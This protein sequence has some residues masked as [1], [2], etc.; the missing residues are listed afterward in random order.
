VHIKHTL[1]IFFFFF[2]QNRDSF[3]SIQPTMASF[4]RYATDGVDARI[5]AKTGKMT[6]QSPT[7]TPRFPLE[8]LFLFYFMRGLIV[9]A[10]AGKQA[11]PAGWLMSSDSRRKEGRKE[12]SK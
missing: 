8:T 3:A 7:P 12:S 1:L 11:R 5:V 4:Y 9:P 2:L 6:I 10:V